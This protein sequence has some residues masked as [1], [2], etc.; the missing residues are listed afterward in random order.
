VEEYPSNLMYPTYDASAIG[1]DIRPSTLDINALLYIYSNDGFGSSNLSPE[2]I[3][4]TYTY[5]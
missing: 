4:S 5:P 1:Y 3:L 2:D